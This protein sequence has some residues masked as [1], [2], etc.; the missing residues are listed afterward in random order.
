MVTTLVLSHSGKVFQEKRPGAIVSAGDVVGRLELEDISLVP[1]A[2]PY[3]GD[4][5]YKIKKIYIAML[6]KI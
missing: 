4:E 2:Q 5:K 3:K 6:R 1:Q